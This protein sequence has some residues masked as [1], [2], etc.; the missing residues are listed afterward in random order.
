MK[1]LLITMFAIMAFAAVTVCAVSGDGTEEAPYLIT[2]QEELLL[3]SDFP[4][5][6]FRLGNDI[7]LE[8]KWTPLCT[9]GEDFT[10]VFDGN[11]YTISN[12]DL[13]SFYYN[14]LFKT[15]S[16]TIKNLNVSAIDGGINISQSNSYNGT[17]YCGII[18]AENN[19]KISGCRANGKINIKNTFIGKYNNSIMYLGAA[20]GK[21]EGSVEYVTSNMDI[22][23]DGFY[24]EYIGGILGLNSEKATVAYSS[25]HGT[26]GDSY[27]HKCGGISGNNCGNINNSYFVG[28]IDSYSGGIAYS[29]TGTIENCYA[30]AQPINS[31]NYRG[32][33][34]D[35]TTGTSVTN[36]FYDQTVS[37]ATD[38]EYGMPKSTLA[39]K[40]KRTF[41]NAN[42]DFEN[43]WRIDKDINDGY[44]YL[45]WEYRTENNQPRYTLNSIQIKNLSGE[46]ITEIPEKNFYAEVS[47]TKNDNS[48]DKDLLIIA[49]Y[50]NADKLI[51]IKYMS[52]TY[53]QNQTVNFGTMINQ[54]DAKIGTKKSFIWNNISE[55]IPLSNIVKTEK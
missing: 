47:V 42:W 38:T 33:V 2:N 5:S 40:M 15:N 25:A 30:V 32:L 12:L 43:V 44:P 1:K 16:G 17:W 9:Y 46:V 51:D 55:I 28:T 18:A 31:S 13:A 53:Y 19:G 10:G 6:C 11:G 7:A 8:G 21:N 45:L 24:L 54:T 27:F 49:A 14:G 50:D 20:V 29:C 34:Y 36:S 35:Y 37:K 3:V 41:T 23:A 26:I 22:S 39:M 48:K 52:G 4:D